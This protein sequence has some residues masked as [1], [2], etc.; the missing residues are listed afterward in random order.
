M[1]PTIVTLISLSLIAFIAE[2]ASSEKYPV[3]EKGIQSLDIAPALG[4]GYDSV[5]ETLRSTCLYFDESIDLT[6]T[7]AEMTCE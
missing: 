1:N 6:A 7:Q 5:T 4:R 2:D 3:S